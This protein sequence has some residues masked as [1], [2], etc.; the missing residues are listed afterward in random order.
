MTTAKTTKN[1]SRSP[2]R[3]KGGASNR[4]DAAFVKNILSGLVIASPTRL[5]ARSLSPP[6]VGRACE[7][8]MT[9]A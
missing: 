1:R 5:T 8:P 9:V 6:S 7:T 4:V 2:G 3:R